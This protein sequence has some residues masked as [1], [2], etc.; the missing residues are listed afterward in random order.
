M[1]EFVASLLIAIVT[2]TAQFGGS[3]AVTS[4]DPVPYTQV[5]VHFPCMPYD[6][7]TCFLIVDSAGIH[8]GP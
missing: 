4:V 8:T 1:I 3:S 2:G 6:G 7:E 5:S